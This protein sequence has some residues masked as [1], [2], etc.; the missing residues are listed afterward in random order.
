VLLILLAA[1]GCGDRQREAHLERFLDT[2]AEKQDYKVEPIDAF[3]LPEDPKTA[4]HINTM[5]FSEVAKRLGPHR[6]RAKTSFEFQG[7]ETRA[8][9]REDDLIV[10]AQNGDFRVKVEN[11]AGQGYELLYSGGKFYSRNRFGPFHP[12]KILTLDHIKWRDAAYQSWA[13]VYRLFRGRLHF[14]KQELTRHH[15]RDALRFGISLS[16]D[17]PRLPG[18]P[19]PPAVPEGVNEYVY[20]IQPTPSARDRWRDNAVPQ[21]AS[22]SILVD[23]DCG[24]IL[25]ANLTGKLTLPGPG[26]GKDRSGGIQLSVSAKLEA[27]GFGNPPSIA[28]PGEELVKPVP[29]RIQVDTHPLDFFFGK[30]FTASLGPPAGVA[31]D[32]KKDKDGKT[33]GGSASKP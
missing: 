4:D 29:E 33:K 7:T 23:A 21:Q 8:S 17:Q 32:R 30:G 20:P 3:L 27:D 9:L 5:A 2:K 14:T 6:Y 15:G 1:P 13:A 24:V 11:D 31:A 28:P 22:G 25:K 16:R 12:R 19:Q 18:T 26:T 10:L